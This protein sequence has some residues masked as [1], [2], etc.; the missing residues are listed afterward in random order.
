M[1][2]DLSLTQ[3]CW[4][5]LERHIDESEFNKD[6]IKRCY[7]FANK[8]HINQKRDSGDPYIT[9]P[10]WIAKVALQL[11][12]GEEAVLAA[13][14]HD[15]VEDTKVT[16]D[17]IAEQFGDEVALLVSGLT[18]VAKKTKG[19]EVNQLNIELFRKFLFSSVDDVR[20]L[21]LRLI[22]KLHNGLTIKYIS[23]ERQLRYGKNIL[24]VY[25]PVAEYVGLHFFKKM[26]EDIAFKIVY[27]EE[28]EELRKM[29]EDNRKNEIKAL[30]LVNKELVELLKINNI[31]GAVVEGR[32]KSLY[33]TFLKIQ[34]KGKDR[35][36]DRVALRILTENV[37]DCYTILGLL[38]AKYKYLEDEFVDYI[39]NPKPNGYRSIQTTVNWKEKL[40][41]EIQIKTKEMHEFNEFGPASH[42]AYK[43]GKESVENGRGMEWVKDLVKW[44]KNE[45]DINNYRLRV[46]TNYIYVFTPKGDT[47]QLSSKSTGLDFAYRIHTEVGDHCNGVKINGKMA[48]IDTQLKTGDVV[49]V[50]MNK[51][52]NVNKNWLEIA[53]TQ[54]AR[55]HIRKVTKIDESEEI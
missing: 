39:A 52:L 31:N 40:T 48:K 15:C 46:L 55:E 44:Q 43:L 27:P 38:H 28:A 11:H 50:L 7:D 21:I 25:G 53:K 47:I 49:E 1:P 29:F 2:I 34:K 6:L 37:A 8:A 20:V 32:I 35:I 5:D 17:Q 3:N 41:V 22:D 18:E 16:I 12:I 19:I 42:I 45:K 30:A 9:H 33:S 26:V 54:W 10:A 13:L 51:K 24:R 14:L 4:A 23:P 36:K